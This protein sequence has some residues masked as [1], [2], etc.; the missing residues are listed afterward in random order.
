MRRQTLS[1]RIALAAVVLLVP[2]SVFAQAPVAAKPAPAAKDWTMPR[3]PDGT[4]DLQ[5][6]Y[7][8]A[9]NVPVSLNRHFILPHECFD[10][11]DF[12][13]GQGHFRIVDMTSCMNSR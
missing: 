4:P 12:A 8:N 5:G 9:T 11:N 1:T 3:T 6:V 7:S 10:T 2:A 13:L